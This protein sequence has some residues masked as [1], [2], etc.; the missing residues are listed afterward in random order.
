MLVEGRELIA[1]ELG[2]GVLVAVGAEAVRMPRGIDQLV[3]VSIG[4]GA[5]VVV[6]AAQAG[7]NLAAQLFDLIRRED[8]LADDVGDQVEGQRQILDQAARRDGGGVTAGA[9]AEAHSG[10][11]DGLVDLLKGTPVRAAGKGGG[12]E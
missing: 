3:K 1:V 11:V 8:R 10:G 7:D 5:G 2:D 4:D 6:G 12:G 9:G